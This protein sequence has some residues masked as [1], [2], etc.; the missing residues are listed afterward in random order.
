MPLLRDRWGGFSFL[1]EVFKPGGF[2]DEALTNGYLAVWG[3]SAFHEEFHEPSTSRVYWAAHWYL[4]VSFRSPTSL[5]WGLSVLPGVD[6]D[7]A[8]HNCTD[9][10]CYETVKEESWQDMARWKTVDWAFL[11]LEV[12]KTG[13]SLGFAKGGTAEL[14]LWC[15]CLISKHPVGKEWHPAVRT[16]I[17]FNVPWRKQVVKDIVIFIAGTILFYLYSTIV[18]DF[19]WILL[20]TMLYISGLLRWLPTLAEEPDFFGN[21][22]KCPNKAPWCNLVEGG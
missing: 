13:F 21:D 19:W 22:P 7:L 17:L 8:I 12:I 9:F 16:V 6:S 5:W 20:L 10:D 1:Y 11:L 4:V 2:L 15:S 14:M 3:F 18:D